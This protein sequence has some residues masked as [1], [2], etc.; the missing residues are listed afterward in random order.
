M[1][2]QVRAA[3]ERS[4]EIDPEHFAALI[5]LAEIAAESDQRAEAVALYD[6]AAAADEGDPAPAYAA[7]L[8]LSSPE[9]EEAVRRLEALLMSHPRHGPP[10]N[11][12]AV[13]FAE[14]GDLDRALV[15]IIL[16]A[17]RRGRVFTRL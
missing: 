9:S 15:Y 12:L 4:I 5:G 2:F 16:R 11:D 13:I 7:A 3:Y 17:V 6:R 1:I 14:R 10:A 8:L